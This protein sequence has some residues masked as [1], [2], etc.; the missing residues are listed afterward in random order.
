MP[1]VIRKALVVLLWMVT[2]PLGGADLLMVLKEG[3]ISGTFRRSFF[4]QDFVTGGKLSQVT[5]SIHGI[6]GVFSFLYISGRGTQ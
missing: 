4:Q 2:R 3:G 1:I 6:S 5:G